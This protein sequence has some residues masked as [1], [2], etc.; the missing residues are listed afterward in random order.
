M[1]LPILHAAVGSALAA[2][3]LNRGRTN[4]PLIILTAFLAIVPDFDFLPGLISGHA[5]AFHRTF[6]HSLVGAA[7]IAGIAALIAA[8]FAGN[9]DGEWANGRSGV[10]TGGQIRSKTT[11]QAYYANHE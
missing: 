4:W 3:T 6:S 7:V 5:A 1:P 11:S 10:D 2:R 8:L 9:R